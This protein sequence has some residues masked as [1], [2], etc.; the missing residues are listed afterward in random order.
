MRLV[1]GLYATALG[2]GTVETFSEDAARRVGCDVSEIVLYAMEPISLHGEQAGSGKASDA[3]DSA[4]RLGE[5]GLAAGRSSDSQ[6]LLRLEQ[7]PNLVDTELDPCSL[8]CIVAPGNKRLTVSR[9]SA[10]LHK[11]QTLFNSLCAPENHRVQRSFVEA[12]S[13]AEK[14]RTACDCLIAANQRAA[15]L[16][17]SVQRNLTAETLKHVGIRASAPNP[18]VGQPAERALPFQSRPQHAR[19]PLKTV[20]ALT[21]LSMPSDPMIRFSR[22]DRRAVS[23][24]LEES[25]PYTDRQ[26]LERSTAVQER[27]TAYMEAYRKICQRFDDLERRPVSQAQNDA[28]DSAD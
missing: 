3:V 17:M 27:V 4:G 26:V 21:P 2:A 14:L 16:L 19:S 24:L 7:L 8:Y 9:L 15:D 13:L 10:T 11:H 12:L 5:G 28:D 22:P 18:A 1:Y 25:A 6:G 20:S 23:A